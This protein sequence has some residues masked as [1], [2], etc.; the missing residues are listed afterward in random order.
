LLSPVKLDYPPQPL[1]YRNSDGSFDGN[2]C[3]PNGKLALP[4]SDFAGLPG[5]ASKSAFYKHRRS[6]IASGILIRA[7]GLTQHG[8]QPDL[9]AIADRFLRSHGVGKRSVRK[10]KNPIPYVDK[11]LLAKMR[12]KPSLADIARAKNMR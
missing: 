2:S 4:N 8:K 7:G 5:F 6:V 10:G 11:Q 3:N 9:F 1:S 12:N